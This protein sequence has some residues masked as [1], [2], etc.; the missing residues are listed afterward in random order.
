MVYQYSR[1]GPVSSEKHDPAAEAAADEGGG[2]AAGV[3]TVTVVVGSYCPRPTS[4]PASIRLANSAKALRSRTCG[5]LYS[6]DT[7]L[8]RLAE[9]CEDVPPALGAFVQEEHPMVRQR[10]LARQ[11]DLAAADQPHI[12]HGLVGRTRRAGGYD[13]CLPAGEPGGAEVMHAWCEGQRGSSRPSRCHPHRQRHQP[14]QINRVRDI[15]F[16]GYR[17]R[18][19]Y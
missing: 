15:I 18:T 1:C 5:R 17:S 19:P 3:V 16:V 13:G 14:M 9:H 2:D 6:C 8:E 11:R 4:L 7:L 10:H 12:Q